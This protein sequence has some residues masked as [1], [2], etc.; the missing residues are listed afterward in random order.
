MYPFRV[1][2]QVWSRTKWIVG[3]EMHALRRKLLGCGHA[4][5]IPN[6]CKACGVRTRRNVMGTVLCERCTAMPI[7]LNAY[8]VPRN[9]V[10]VVLR[11][12]RDMNVIRSDVCASQPRNVRWKSTRRGD[13]AF[14]HEIIAV[15]GASRTLFRQIQVWS[16]L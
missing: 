12:M 10:S 13:V 3:A 2:M 7:M 8:M 4:G 16:R 5:V 6:M 1:R 14:L 15:T 9:T 11:R